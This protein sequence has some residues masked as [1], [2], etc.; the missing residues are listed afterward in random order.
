MAM[1]Q[2]NTS[3]RSFE[4]SLR[5]TASSEPVGS[6]A[7]ALAQPFDQSGSTD[8][9]PASMSQ[10]TTRPS[11]PLVARCRPSAENALAAVNPSVWPPSRRRRTV[12]VVTSRRTGTGRSLVMATSVPP[13]CAVRLVI[14]PVGPGWPVRD[15][16]P[17]L[18]DGRR[19]PDDDV[20]VGR[21]I[22]QVV[23]PDAAA[24]QGVDERPTVACDGREVELIAGR[25]AT[26]ARTAG[27]AAGRRR[28]PTR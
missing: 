18:G 11:Y 28:D 4:S 6:K 10:M 19:V 20:A 2:R 1:S 8:S 17:D 13:G 7:R 12:P 16:D 27:S 25:H 23:E 21:G 5:P 9:V 14:S 15:G 24:G 3:P 26:R 22:R